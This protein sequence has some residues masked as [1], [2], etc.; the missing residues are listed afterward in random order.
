MPTSV[1]RFKDSTW[2]ICPLQW[3]LKWKRE[4]R[5]GVLEE[6]KQ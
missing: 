1:I 4:K 5:M 6:M 3:Q 2:V